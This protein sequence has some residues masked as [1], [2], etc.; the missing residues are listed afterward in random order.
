M[1]SNSKVDM[2]TGPI[3]KNIFIFAIPIIISNILQNLYSTVDTLVVG[4]FCGETSLAAIGTS[5]QPIEVVLCVFLGI[6]GGVSILISQYTG[7]KDTQAIK[8]TCK[9]AVTFVYLAG[10]P[11]TIIGVILTPWILTRMGVPEDTFA[12]AVAYTRIS[13]LGTLANV[14]YNMNAGILRGMGDSRASLNFL[15]VSCCSNIILDLI[16]VPVLKLDAAGAALAT[17]SAQYLA[18]IASVVYTKKKFSEVGF[19]FLPKGC[20]F[21]ALKQ[22]VVFGLP[23]G[24]NNSLFSLGHL[25]MQ[26]FVNAQGSTFMAANAV[27]GR[28]SGLSNI[29]I[30]ALSQ[31]GSAYSGQ[32]FGAKNIERLKQGY[33]KIPFVSGAITLAFGM[34]FMSIRM[35]ILKLFTREEMV[36]FYA[37]RYVVVQ[38]SSQWMFA[39]YNSI[40]NIVN[41]TGR[42]KYTTIVNLMMLWVVRIP[43]AYLIMKLWDGTWIMLSVAISFLFGMS[44]MLGYYI[45]SKSWKK[46]LSGEII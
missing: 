41:G 25:F 9:T 30:Q 10:L 45:F 4:N 36:L 31:A 39:V 42:L 26:S 44:A 43:S 40:T 6:G 2:T 14:G 19:S 32:N 16:F 28:I 20:S 15:I 29:A 5:A 23:I 46:M 21:E 22:I 12:I 34:F 33:L 37:S 17:I 24:L 7:A 1:K 35:P 13:F 27:A 18:W 3:M 8:S 11:L 38:L